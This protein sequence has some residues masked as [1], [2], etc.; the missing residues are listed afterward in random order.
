MSQDPYGNI[1]TKVYDKAGR[2]KNVIDGDASSGT[3]CAT[4][5]YNPNGSRRSLTYENGSKAEYTYWENGLLKKL[6]NMDS[7]ETV[8]DE[9]NYE[10]DEAQNMENKTE[11]INN[12]NKGTTTYQYD[13]LNRLKT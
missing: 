6:V 12:V 9:Y 7:L 8:I 2:L 5:E 13:E 4:Y 10:Y 1:T 11:I 3:L